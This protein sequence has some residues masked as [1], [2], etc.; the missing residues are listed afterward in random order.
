MSQQHVLQARSSGPCQA[1]D[2]HMGD[3]RCW[4]VE[5]FNVV[6]R[7]AC[8]YLRPSADHFKTSSS[9]RSQMQM[10]VL[11]YHVWVCVDL[12]YGDMHGVAGLGTAL[13]VKHV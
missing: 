7:V 12:W 10:D 1:V 9:V 8:C 2:R 4:H 5:R 11:C 13:R 3:A 6:Y